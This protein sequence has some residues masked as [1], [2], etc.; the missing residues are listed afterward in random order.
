[1]RKRLFCKQ[2]NSLYGNDESIVGDNLYGTY[3]N[4]LIG[5]DC[6]GPSNRYNILGL[7][8]RGEI[9]DIDPIDVFVLELCYLY[10][11]NQGIHDRCD[12]RS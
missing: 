10:V 1:M 5:K 8:N 11:V 3:A 6:C 9:A 4:M 7:H 12:T 2:D